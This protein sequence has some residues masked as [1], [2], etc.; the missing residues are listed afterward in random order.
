MPRKILVELEIDLETGSFKF[1]ST[2]S[3]PVTPNS[4]NILTAANR[5]F[6]NMLLSEYERGRNSVV[7][8]VLA[9]I[10]K[11]LKS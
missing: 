2:D 8:N 3:S 9:G 1:N 11:F 6:G 7:Q 5:W 4:I 10:E